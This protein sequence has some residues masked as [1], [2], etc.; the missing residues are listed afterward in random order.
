[1]CF[2][3]Y[4]SGRQTKF[5]QGRDSSDDRDD[6]ETD[7]KIVLRE[8]GEVSEEISGTK[9][10]LSR[11]T[12]RLLC[13]PPSLSSQFYINTHKKSPTSM[14]LLRVSQSSELLLCIITKGTVG[15]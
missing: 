8:G 4:P 6:T 7:S 9:A 10:Q 14:Q 5:E 12:K 3:A 11:A 1:M 2:F 15:E 13:L